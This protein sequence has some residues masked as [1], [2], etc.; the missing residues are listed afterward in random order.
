MCIG[1]S[2]SLLPDTLT[3]KYELFFEGGVDYQIFFFVQK[4][5]ENKNTLPLSY[6]FI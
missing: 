2:L 1:L 3:A 4:K 5:G 6:D